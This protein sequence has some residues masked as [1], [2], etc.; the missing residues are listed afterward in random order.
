MP[1]KDGLTKTTDIT[2]TAREVDFVTRFGR[3]WDSL[4]EILGIMRPVRKA[5]GTKLTSYEATV[6]LAEGKVEE[7]TEI[8]YSQAKVTPVTYED[9]ELDKWAKAVSIESVNKYGATVAVQRTDEAFLNELQGKVL[10]DFYTFLQSGTLKPAGATNLQMGIALAIGS[11]V[12]KFKKLRRDTTNIVVFVNTMDAYKYLGAAEIS[13]QTQ[14]GLTYLQN[15]MGAGT[16]I[17]SSEIPEGTVIATPADNI[18]LYYV[19]PGDGE[20]AQLGLDYTVQGETNLIGFHAN[21][22]YSTAV[23]ESFALMGMKLWAEYI[24]AI[25]VVNTSLVGPEGVSALGQDE[26]VGDKKV[27]AVCDISV[28]ATDDVVEVFGTTVKQ[29]S[30]GQWEGYGQVAASDQFVILKMPAWFAGKDIYSYTGS[31]KQAHYPKFADDRILIMKMNGLKEATD[32]TQR[33]FID[34]KEVLTVDYSGVTLAS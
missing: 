2:V 3:N 6:T 34:G 25:A 18:V 17:L 19:D 11:V 9:L 22:N 27:S 24:D 10:G 8:P 26:Q 21:G 5:P 1:A 28:V 32:K 30:A 31:G 29:A 4:R 20:F 16:M 33:F 23:G 14:N 15:F 7:G 12:D 13:V